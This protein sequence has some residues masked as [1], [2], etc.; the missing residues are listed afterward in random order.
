MEDLSEFLE[1]FLSNWQ[2]FLR[3]AIA[4]FL[5]AVSRR[6][7]SKRIRYAMEK[8]LSEL[9]ELVQASRPK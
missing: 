8:L 9:R 4:E 5:K 2:F 6:K 7:D 1:F 3:L